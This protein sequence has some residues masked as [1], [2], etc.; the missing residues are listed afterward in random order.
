MWDL[1]FTSFAMPCYSTMY[2]SISHVR[3]R[4]LLEAVSEMN[5]KMLFPVHTEHPDAYNNVSKNLTIV[6]DIKYDI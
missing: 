4:D 5:T 1:P 6:E 2:F 3:C